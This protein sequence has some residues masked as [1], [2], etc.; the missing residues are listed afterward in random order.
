MAKQEK[1]ANRRSFKSS[2]SATLPAGAVL[3]KEPGEGFFS[4][5][6]RS[7]RVRKKGKFVLQHSF[8]DTE[9]S[10]RAGSARLSQSTDLLKNTDAENNGVRGRFKSSESP[11]EA[12]QDNKNIVSSNSESQKSST[13]ACDRSPSAE[14]NMPEGAAKISDDSD[15]FR[16]QGE[17]ATADASDVGFEDNNNDKFLDDFDPDYD[18]LDNIRQK[19]Q[20]RN[21]GV[22]DGLA[23]KTSNNL[24]KAEDS[25]GVSGSD[26]KEQDPC[27]PSSDRSEP[28][29][30][31]ARESVNSISTPDPSGVSNSRPLLSAFE[32][33][34]YANA[35]ILQRKQLRRS[36]ELTTEEV[37]SGIKSVPN[38]AL[39][40]RHR[41]SLQTESSQCVCPPPL[42]ARNY[43][44]K[45]MATSVD[46]SPFAKNLNNNVD[47]NGT[48][49]PAVAKPEPYCSDQQQQ[50]STIN[51][52]EEVNDRTKPN[53]PDS[54]SEHSKP[55][56]RDSA[57]I[58]LGP[59]LILNS[60]GNNRH[61]DMQL[62]L[63]HSNC[64]P[65]FLTSA[66]S[67]HKAVTEKACSEEQMLQTTQ[68]HKT[69]Q[70]IED[71]LLFIDEDPVLDHDCQAN[72]SEVMG[73][74]RNA[75]CTEIP[76]TVCKSDSVPVSLESNKKT[77]SKCADQ[78]SASLVM[79]ASPEGAQG[80]NMSWTSQSGNDQEHQDERESSHQH[81]EKSDSCRAGSS[82]SRHTLEETFP[83]PGQ[84]NSSVSHQT[85]YTAPPVA[86]FPSVVLHPVVGG[87][88]S[89]GEGEKQHG[90][91]DSQPQ[92]K[93]QAS[94]LRERF[95]QLSR[96]THS[97]E[98]TPPPLPASRRTAGRKVVS[99]EL[100]L[101]RV[102]DP[103]Q[104]SRKNRRH[105]SAVD[106]AR[107]HND[108]VTSMQQLKECRWYWGP[109]SS[110]EAV[111][112]L[113][114]KCDGSFLVRDS[115]SDKHLLA[116]SFKHSNHVHHTR[117]EFHKGLFS[118]WERPDQNS[119][120]HICQ[121]VEQM[122]ERS[123]QGNF[124]YFKR[125]ADSTANPL[126]IQLL[127]PVSRFHRVPSLQ[128]ICRFLILCRTRRDH[129]DKLP[130]PEKV[131][132]YL[133]EK[134]YY[135]EMLSED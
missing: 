130:L 50:G 98:E 135:V 3:T 106:A 13:E 31:H 87:A 83:Q 121:F 26:R 32:D 114:D 131:K 79:S 56:R 36:S 6:R 54:H 60:Q 41:G 59:I 99:Q 108:F 124:I 64:S 67:V 88:A 23:N 110:E 24:A 112:K 46:S 75:G 66:N 68:E 39:P 1:K 97:W 128:H 30:T 107:A 69:L 28:T 21:S 42:P 100:P 85:A 20:D 22:Q 118:F 90:E 48:Q 12:G 18:T 7:F 15:Q 120:A 4:K 92:V 52:T 53:T 115:A 65:I 25:Q 43:L 126:S 58:E 95:V 125:S 57:F 96:A 70:Q 132:R 49:E 76:N 117:I 61:S 45:D 72:S 109:L 89:N 94:L 129:I 82:Q 16:S 80:M 103:D 81:L 91:E 71:D 44:E 122:V 84:R 133:S 40:P 17:Q 19:L 78:L 5:I 62:H 29:M 73:S 123:K 105:S 127:Y 35:K 27:E 116:I 2:K 10:E 9:V 8:D 34:L 102:K 111:S 77:D 33:D 14:E 38:S 101:K 55:F 93:S 47:M 11:P 119:K 37:N 51:T 86:S 113:K 63:P 134:Q 74:V 104:E